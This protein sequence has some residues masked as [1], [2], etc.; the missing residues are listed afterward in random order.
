MK[1]VTVTITTD[2]P[3]NVRITP[4]KDALERLFEVLGGDEEVSGDDGCAVEA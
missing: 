2:V 1:Q 4:G 3:V